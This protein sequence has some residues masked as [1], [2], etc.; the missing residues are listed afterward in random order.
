MK[1]FFV[2]EKIDNNLMNNSENNFPLTRIGNLI[3]EGRINKNLSITELASNLKISEERLKAIEEGREDLLPEKVFIKA[4]IR[5]ISEKLK[6]DTELVIG[7]L[8]NKPQEEKVEDNVEEVSKEVKV[9][10]KNPLGFFLI[11]IISGVVGLLASS[12]VFNLIIDIKTNQNEKVL[13]KTN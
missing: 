6:L 2:L 9:S 7:E 3:K 12:F 4:M 11:I 1:R 10:R 8:E 5:R 13:I